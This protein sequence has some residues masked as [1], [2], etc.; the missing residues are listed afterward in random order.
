MSL[1]KVPC[2]SLSLL[3]SYN[4]GKSP[5]LKKREKETRMTNNQK[6]SKPSVLQMDRIA[7]RNTTKQKGKE[8]QKLEKQANLGRGILCFDQSSHKTYFGLLYP[9]AF[10]AL[11]FCFRGAVHA[12]RTHH[13]HHD[14]RFPS[15]VY[16]YKPCGRRLYFSTQRLIF[17]EQN[18]VLI[19]HVSNIKS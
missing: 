5:K 12:I 16:V 18:L 11:F 19:G 6:R 15:S 2:V 3:E 17:S 8:S 4:E 13:H 10:K 1:Y 14:S 9:I 7:A